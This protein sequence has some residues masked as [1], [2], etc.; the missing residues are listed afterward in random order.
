MIWIFVDRWFQI[1]FNWFN[2]NKL[3]F[4]TMADILKNI[5]EQMLF[6]IIIYFHPFD[7]LFFLQV[8]FF[9][10]ELLLLSFYIHLLISI[11]AILLLVVH[12]FISFFHLCILLFF[13]LVYAEF[14]SVFTLLLVVILMTDLV[15]VDNLQIHRWYLNIFVLF[16]WH[17]L[18]SL[19]PYHGFKQNQILLHAQN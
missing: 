4:L 14:L 15:L 13:L 19:F 12:F 8:F 9:T 2:T 18:R 10:P 1:N 17:F 3:H 6:F 16:Y 7:Y 11:S 5:L